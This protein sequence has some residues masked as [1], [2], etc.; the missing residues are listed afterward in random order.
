MKKYLLIV[1]AVFLTVSFTNSFAQEKENVKKEE[2]VQVIDSSKVEKVNQAS[3]VQEKLNTICPVSNE[4]ADPEITYAYNGKTYS[5][6]CNKCL[7]K[8]KANPEKYISRMEKEKS[9]SEA[10]SN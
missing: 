5:L 8:F 3:I 4:E 7:K 10:Q 2:K 1:F 9:S 6:C